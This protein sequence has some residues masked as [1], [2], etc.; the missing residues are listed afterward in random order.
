[1]RRR[2]QAIWSFIVVLVAVSLLLSSVGANAFPWPDWSQVD[3]IVV[4]KTGDESSD[5]D[6]TNCYC[7]F[8]RDYFYFRVDVLGRPQKLGT[9]IYMDT[10][11]NAATGCSTG[12]LGDHA[13]GAEYYADP[14]ATA[15]LFHWDQNT[16]SWVPV[17]ALPFMISGHTL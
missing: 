14:I 4:D 7:T 2:H 17:E 6:I 11:N 3:P 12:F 9:C 8:D 10:D 15:D 13:I 5:Y 1:M 16:M